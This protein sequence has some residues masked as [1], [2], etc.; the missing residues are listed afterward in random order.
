M[1]I[2]KKY[3]INKLKQKLFELSDDELK[4]K[5]IY[6][7]EIKIQKNHK[8]SY[9]L[10]KLYNIFK[11][12][13]ELVVKCDFIT[14][15][16]NILLSDKKVSLVLETNNDYIFGDSMFRYS[17]TLSSKNQYDTI[18]ELVNGN[19]YKNILNKDKIQTN[20]NTQIYKIENLFPLTNEIESE[21]LSGVREALNYFEDNELTIEQMVDFN[22]Y[23]NI[24]D[25]STISY[26]SNI[27]VSKIINFI[28]NE[29]L[30]PN[31]KDLYEDI[32]ES[33]IE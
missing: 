11:R 28:T 17:V 23:Y 7:K 13:D 20:I 27:L 26:K 21:F 25:D 10:Y 2:N 29:P 24:L 1:E 19:V 5:T 3:D 32:K 4:N 16:N 9:I 30:D 6:L 31:N 15:D 22:N 14:V 8:I 18:F 12:G 33:L